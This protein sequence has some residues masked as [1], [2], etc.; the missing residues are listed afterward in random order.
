MLREIPIDP[1][2]GGWGV[3]QLDVTVVGHVM[4]VSED[5]GPNCVD[6]RGR[7]P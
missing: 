4:W 7:I 2:S 3:D 6:Y 5:E 1:Y